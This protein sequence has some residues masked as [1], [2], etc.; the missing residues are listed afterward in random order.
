MHGAVFT[1][2]SGRVQVDDQALSLQAQEVPEEHQRD[3]RHSLHGS[4]RAGEPFNP[5]PSTLD[6]KPQTLPRRHEAY[7]VLAVS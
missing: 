7:D 2:C 4:S 3:S 5:Q 1:V 6:R